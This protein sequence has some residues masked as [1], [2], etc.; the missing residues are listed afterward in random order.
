MAI[1]SAAQAVP[2]WREWRFWSVDFT[3]LEQD[4]DY[5]L[6]CRAESGTQAHTLR[7]SA[8][9]V[10][11]N[12]LERHT[13]SNVIAYF[14]AQRSSGAIDRADAQIPFSDPQRP[15]ID[16]HGGWYDATGDYGTQVVNAAGK[17][18]LLPGNTNRMVDTGNLFSADGKSGGADR[19]ITKLSLSTRRIALITLSVLSSMV[20]SQ[21]NAAVRYGPSILSPGLLLFAIGRAPRWSVLDR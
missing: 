5:F 18:V 6:E 10:Q 3:E 16:A 17:T 13:L 21:K 15:R 12:L 1:P 11:R 20:R 14:K 4:G 7:S 9:L 19:S 8:F 2:G